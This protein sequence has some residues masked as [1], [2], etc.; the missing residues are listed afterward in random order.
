MQCCHLM[1]KRASLSNKRA[2][3][4]NIRKYET[5]K[6]LSKM[7]GFGGSITRKTSCFGHFDWNEDESLE[8]SYY[9]G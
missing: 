5:P 7:K 1:N 8:N 6:N 2:S 4:S 9:P 3:L